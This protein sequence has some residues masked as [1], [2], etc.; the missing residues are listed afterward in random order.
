MRSIGR[1]RRRFDPSKE[2]TVADLPSPDVKRWVASRKAR[3]VL[4]VRE[5]LLPLDEV[6]ERYTLSLDEFMSW[7]RAFAA[8]GLKGLM[9]STAKR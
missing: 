7:W 1:R 6:L 2:S 5:G 4:A 8:G 9:V 3:V